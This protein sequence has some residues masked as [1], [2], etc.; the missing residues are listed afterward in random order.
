MTSAQ[1]IDLLDPNLTPSEQAMLRDLMKAGEAYCRQGRGREYHAIGKALAIVWHYTRR[2][3]G[4]PELPRTDFG[5]LDLPLPLEER[6]TAAAAANE[7]PVRARARALSWGFSA[8]T[9]D[10]SVVPETFS[11]NR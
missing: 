2:T 4:Q 8:N 1:D 11:L 3:G 10:D 5:S 9:P 6:R 7:A